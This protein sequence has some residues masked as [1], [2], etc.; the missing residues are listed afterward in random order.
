MSKEQLPKCKICGDEIPPR[1]LQDTVP[2]Y[3]DFC[4]AEGVFV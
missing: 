4:I 2:E 1:Y 3:C